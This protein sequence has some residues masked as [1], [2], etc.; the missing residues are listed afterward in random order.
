MSNENDIREPILRLV[1]R[2]ADINY[3]GHVFGGWI[4]SE[5]DIAGGLVAA[6]RAGRRVATVAVEAMKFI[7]PVLVGDW[8][9]VYADIVKVGRTSVSVHVEVVVRRQGASGGLQVTEG[10]FVYVALGDDGGP[11]PVAPE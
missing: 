7:R 2:P 10:L 4:L 8:L 11:T 9:S 3:N 1:P 6:R 5:M